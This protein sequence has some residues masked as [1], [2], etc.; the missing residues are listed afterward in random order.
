MIKTLLARLQEPS[1]YAGLA[2]ILGLL[3]ISLP[4]E[5]LQ[6]IVK[7]L[8]AGAGLAAIFVSEKNGNPPTDTSKPA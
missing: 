1:T 7:V 2:T 5:K 6:A 8:I 3:H 4:D